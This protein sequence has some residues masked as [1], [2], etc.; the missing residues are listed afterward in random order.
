MLKTALLVF[1]CVSVI[2]VVA[3]CFG[4]LVVADD[5]NRSDSSY[6]GTTPTGGYTWNEQETVATG[7]RISGNQAFA[8]STT[9]GREYATIDL[10]SSSSYSTTLNHNGGT[11]TWT[12]NMRGS[13]LDPSGFDTGNYG[14]A[15]V[16]ASTSSSSSSGQGYAVVLGQS[17]STDPI[18]LARFSG[19]LNLNS[20][21]QNI[22]S[23]GDFGSEF[24]NIRVTYDPTSDQWSLFATSGASFSDP[25]AV[26]TQVGSTTSDSTYTGTALNFSGFLWNHSTASGEG[27]TF[28]N[29]AIEAVP[30][31]QE[32][33]IVSTV[34]LLGICAF[35]SWRTA[36]PSRPLRS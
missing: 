22:I 13:R 26:T 28:D 12:V 15:F 27:G 33:G 20:S 8:G 4:S 35:R 6:L 7:L 34:G 29:F 16:L 9:S 2:G 18:R 14:L 25:T 3:P 31:P 11:V 19:G 21:F 10:S 32:W 5:F 24:L 23:G 36:R 17:G 1:F 30:E